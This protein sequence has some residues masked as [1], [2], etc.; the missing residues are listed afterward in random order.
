MCHVPL[1]QITEMEDVV[2]QSQKYSATLQSYNTSLQSDVQ[3][4]KAKREELA[5][6]REELQGQVA[7][8]GGMTKSLER[9]LQLEQV[10]FLCL[11]VQR[12]SSYH[13]YS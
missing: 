9:L 13:P 12:G 4:E 2:R 1:V 6:H 11:A 3:A 10:N 7:E 5:R 8:L